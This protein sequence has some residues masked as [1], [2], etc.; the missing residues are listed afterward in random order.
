M[1]DIISILNNYIKVENISILI[2]NYAIL[3]IND[4]KFPDNV[5]VDYRSIFGYMFGYND[6]ILNN[7]IPEYMNYRKI[8]S[9]YL[10]SVNS[11]YDKIHILNISLEN[12]KRILKQKYTST[13]IHKQK[14]LLEHDIK[15]IS[16]II[17]H[18]IHNTELLKNFGH[19]ENVLGIEKLIYKYKNN[20]DEHSEKIYKYIFEKK[21]FRRFP[22]F[23]CC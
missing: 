16:Y 19:I 14:I 20:I 10:Y 18:N 12:L 15:I 3:S 11:L 21:L 5:L 23:L 17:S 6:Y 13:N 4:I 8:F 1:T 7:N 22:R 2:Y 9:K